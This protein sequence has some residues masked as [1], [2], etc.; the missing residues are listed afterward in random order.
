MRQQLQIP[1]LNAQGIKHITQITSLS[2]QKK[3]AKK[4]K[5]VY[6]LDTAEQWVESHVCY[7]YLLH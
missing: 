5:F 1:L 2:K 3:Y 6:C 4:G 7:H